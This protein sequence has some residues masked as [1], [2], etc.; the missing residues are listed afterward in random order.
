MGSTDGQIKV[1]NTEMTKKERPEMRN[2]DLEND[3]GR[4]KFT[5]DEKEGCIQY[6]IS[7]ERALDSDESDGPATFHYS[8]KKFAKNPIEGPRVLIKNIKK[9]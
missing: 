2:L 1:W 5:M 3:T 4:L 6:K 7:K 9:C 8:I